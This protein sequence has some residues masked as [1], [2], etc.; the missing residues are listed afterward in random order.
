[1]DQET[2]SSAGDDIA[3]DSV[4]AS[5]DIQ[6]ELSRNPRILSLPVKII[7]SVGS[8]HLTVK[9]MIALSSDSTV[10]LESKIQDPA[11][12][13]VGEQLIARGELVE[14]DENDQIGVRITEFNEHRD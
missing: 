2:Q 13:Y 12:I 5:S 9:E 10:T 14:A 4:M 11:E 1:M 3:V 6:S 8:A 7:V